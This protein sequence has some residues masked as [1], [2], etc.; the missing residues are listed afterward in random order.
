MDYLEDVVK[1]TPV[2]VTERYLHDIYSFV[3]TH[4]DALGYP[5]DSAMLPY[6]VTS[7]DLVQKFTG[8]FEL[9][10][11]KN[12]AVE[13]DVLKSWIEGLLET[14]SD[15]EN[16]RKNGCCALYHSIS[17]ESVIDLLQPSGT[18]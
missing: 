8:I 13:A 11:R 15:D 17:K 18:V 16:R 5:K 6:F 4:R 2:T 10:K 3:L 1:Q 9:C 14:Y 7:N 12:V